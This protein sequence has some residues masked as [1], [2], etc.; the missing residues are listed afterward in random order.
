MDNIFST[1]YHI[2][3]ISNHKLLIFLL[4]IDSEG[5]VHTNIHYLKLC[6][7]TLDNKF[8]FCPTVLD[9]ITAAWHQRNWKFIHQK[10]YW[11]VFFQSK[12]SPNLQRSNA[13]K[14]FDQ[15]MSYLVKQTSMMLAS[16]QNSKQISYACQSLVKFLNIKMFTNLMVHSA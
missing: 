15:H 16:H 11:I 14:L 2:I 4:D 13:W 8:N 1:N 10:V 3:N 9:L 12:W 7:V 6:C 5:L